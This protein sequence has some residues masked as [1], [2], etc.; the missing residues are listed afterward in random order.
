MQSCSSVSIRLKA[1]LI[2][3]WLHFGGCSSSLDIGVTKK[4]KND[5]WETWAQVEF[6]FLSYHYIDI[7]KVM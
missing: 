4:A 7:N 6:L 1:L 5:V 3:P 2:L